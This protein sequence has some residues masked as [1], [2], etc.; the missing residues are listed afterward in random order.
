MMSDMVAHQLAG[1]VVHALAAVPQPTGS[2]NNS[3]NSIS[4]SNTSASAAHAAARH[5]G[6]LSDTE[7][8]EW[9]TQREAKVERELYTGLQKRMETQRKQVHA[10]KLEQAKWENELQVWYACNPLKRVFITDV[11]CVSGCVCSSR[12]RSLRMI[13]SC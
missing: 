7:A 12:S 3:S 9:W 1:H 5:Y 11:V 13:G 2:N 10:F 6:S 8:R 4:S